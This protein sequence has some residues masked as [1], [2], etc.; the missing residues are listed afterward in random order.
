M[1]VAAE[2][3]SSAVNGAPGGTRTPKPRLPTASRR[4]A[5]ASRPAARSRPRSKTPTAPL[6]TTA[7]ARR[8]SG[9]SNGVI[10][11]T[12]LLLSHGIGDRGTT[13]PTPSSR[14]IKRL[15]VYVGRCAPGCHGC[16]RVSESTT[17]P[18][19][20]DK[21][22]QVR[23][24]TVRGSRDWARR[25]RWVPDERQ[26]CGFRRVRP[27]GP[28]SLFP[29]GEADSRLNNLSHDL[30]TSPERSCPP[31]SIN[32]SGAPPAGGLKRVCVP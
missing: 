30:G 20:Q 25:R 17:S 9:L 1:V 3:T 21:L 22:P 6:R 19:A 16:E 2:S 8:T 31:I 23:W 13:F 27:A 26:G 10:A 11:S 32:P 7:A 18:V 4:R 29:I 14:D 24:F 5:S 15:W 12:V 28:G